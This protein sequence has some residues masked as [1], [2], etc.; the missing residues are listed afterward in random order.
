MEELFFAFSKSIPDTKIIG[1]SLMIK[2]ERLLDRYPD[3]YYI[4]LKLAKNMH[5]IP[6]L[7]TS[8][9]YF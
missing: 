8:S 7:P 6:F 2:N 4:L 1:F 3:R 9:K 5:P